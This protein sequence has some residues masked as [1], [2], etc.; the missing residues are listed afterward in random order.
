MKLDKNL[1][2]TVYWYMLFSSC[3]VYSV[4]AVPLLLY[5]RFDTRT[6]YPIVVG[7]VLGSLFASNMK[8]QELVLGMPWWFCVIAS[9]DS[10]MKNNTLSIQ[11]FGLCL[12]G[13]ADMI[14]DAC[15]IQAVEGNGNNT[16]ILVRGCDSEFGL[17][18]EPGYLKTMWFNSFQFFNIMVPMKS[19]CIGVTARWIVPVP[20]K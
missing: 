13:Y 19:K 2:H 12:E 15:Y 20:S 18:Y 6:L 10:V 14:L 9:R 8:R 1:Y 7:T 17:M 3:S 5:G 11:V 16:P 4:F